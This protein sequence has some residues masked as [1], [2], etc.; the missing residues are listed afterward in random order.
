M[1]IYKSCKVNEYELANLE[2]RFQPDGA[3][4]ISPSVESEE[5]N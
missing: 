5:R 3:A 1:I 2:V 4:I